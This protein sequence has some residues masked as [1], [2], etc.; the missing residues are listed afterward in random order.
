MKRILLLLLLVPAVI[1]AQVKPKAVPGFT[2]NGTVTGFTD[3]TTVT[4]LNGQTG[5]QLDQTTITKG[6]FSFK[7]NMDEADFRILLFNG[8]P[9]FI[10]LFLDNSNLKVTGDKATIAQAVVTG[11]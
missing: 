9:P 3:G 1:F 11:S 7:G 8:Q 5:A 6:K 4:L 10:T 2:I